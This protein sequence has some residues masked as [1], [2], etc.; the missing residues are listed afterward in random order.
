M[1]H[2]EQGRIV[3]T[4]TEA[5]AGTTGQGARWVLVVSTAAV[6]V[7]FAILYVHYFV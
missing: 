4:K 6:V 5:R 7:I 2:R 1:P 3:K